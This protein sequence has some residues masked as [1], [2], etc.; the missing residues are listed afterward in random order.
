MAKLELESVSQARSGKC[1]E[2]SLESIC[3]SKKFNKKN[4]LEIR[5]TNFNIFSSISAR[6]FCGDQS[7][8]QFELSVS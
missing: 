2:N 6:L 8:N 4:W 1:D 3:W 5:E 7:E